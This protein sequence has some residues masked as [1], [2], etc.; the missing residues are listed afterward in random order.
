MK[1]TRLTLDERM[2]ASRA[3][4]GDPWGTAVWIEAEHDGWRAAARVAM[5]D[6]APVLAELRIYPDDGMQHPAGWS[7]APDAVPRG[8][9]TTELVRSALT[10]RLLEA[11]RELYE[12]LAGEPVFEGFEPL[13]SVPACARPR[14]RDDRA[15]AST[16]DAVSRHRNAGSGRPI[17][18]AAAELGYAP[19]TVRNRLTKARDRGI[20]AG[21]KLTDRGRALLGG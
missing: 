15:L 12:P 20:A 19:G 8:G 5:Q 9:L 18:A 7:H 17:D 13:L 16:V 1:A 4:P 6:G 21:D 11:V 10:D 2:T 3:Q 14:K